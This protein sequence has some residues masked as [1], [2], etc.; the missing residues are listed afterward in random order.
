MCNHGRW[1]IRKYYA[2]TLNFSEPRK[3]CLFQNTSIV[4][5]APCGNKQCKN[6]KLN[7]SKITIKMVRMFVL[8]YSKCH[9][10]FFNYTNIDLPSQKCKE[11]YYV[12]ALI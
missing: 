7:F 12:P 6:G 4:L 2:R 8:I 5:T 1:L 3:R 10:D 11:I 9:S